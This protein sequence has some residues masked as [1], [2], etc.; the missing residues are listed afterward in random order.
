MDAAKVIA[1][2]AGLLLSAL[3]VNRVFKSANLFITEYHTLNSYFSA[4]G[5]KS[6]AI[7]LQWEV[8]KWFQG[9]ELK[10]PQDFQLLK[11]LL[12]P[13]THWAQRWWNLVWPSSIYR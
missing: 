1:W 2:Q 5:E 4:L 11:S 7:P 9:K 3:Q 6:I 10:I 12:F 13:E 8:S